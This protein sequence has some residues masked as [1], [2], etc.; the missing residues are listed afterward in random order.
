MSPNLFACNEWED[1]VGQLIESRALVDLNQGVDLRVLTDHKV[2]MLRKIRLKAIH[3]AWDRIEDEK[4][5]VPK[6]EMLK[7]VTGWGRWKCNVYV[8]I[9]FDTTLE[10]DLHRIMECRR[11]GFDPYVMV[12]QKDKLPKQCVQNRL[13][14]WVNFRPLWGKYSTFKEFWGANYKTPYM[15]V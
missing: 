6:M 1:L 14:R 15:E 9:N 4:H 11:I 12:Y 8:L 2:E 13:Q 7:E 3:V 10:E 5:I